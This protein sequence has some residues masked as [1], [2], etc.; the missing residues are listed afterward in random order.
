MKEI[1]L[2]ATRDR[3]PSKILFEVHYL[4]NR[5]GFMPQIHKVKLYARTRTL[6]E[7]VVL[8]MSNVLSII[9]SVRVVNG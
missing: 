4:H 6:A 2:V 8:G 5:P 3:T 1:K 7:G 9:K